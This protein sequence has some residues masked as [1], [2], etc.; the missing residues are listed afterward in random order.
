MIEHH[1]QKDILLRLS[2][3]AELRF[4]ELK[5]EDM[6]SNSFIYHL[7]QLQSQKL[8]DKTE[9]GYRLSDEGLS[10]IDGFSFH[11]LKPRKQPKIITILI[12]KNP[13]GQ[14][15]MAKRKYQPYIGQYMFVSGKQ[16]LGEGPD[17]HVVRELREKLNL[18]V[19]AKR[20]GLSD[21]R[22]YRGEKIITHVTAHIYEALSPTD[23]L[24]EDTH[25]FEFVWVNADDTELPMLAG[26]HEIIEKLGEE[27]ELF[28]LSLDVQDN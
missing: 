12:V 24:P 14:F 16:H 27:K 19:P 13:S 23:Q 20:R 3:A 9:T 8:V 21:I 4:S 5:P 1:I 6:E 17:E 26:T 18:D 7:K 11:T 2:K 15:L 25:Q 22:I 10:Y 28:F